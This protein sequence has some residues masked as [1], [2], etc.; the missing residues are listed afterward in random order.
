MVFSDGSTYYGS[1]TNNQLASTKAVLT[2]AN[3]DKYKGCIQAS[4]RHGEGQ[5]LFKDQKL[6]QLEY[7]G[8]FKDDLREGKGTLAQGQPP[9]VKY[10]GEFRE[11]RRFGKV[12]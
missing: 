11:D 7:K 4:R 2:F 5:Y 10:E 9:Y 6:G 1:F 12:Q 3:G 8:Y